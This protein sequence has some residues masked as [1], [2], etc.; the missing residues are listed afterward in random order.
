MQDEY[1]SVE[2][3]VMALLDKPDRDM[4]EIWSAFGI[5]K[6]DFQ[7]GPAWRSL[8]QCQGEQIRLRRKPM[9]PCTK[10]G[11]DLVELAQEP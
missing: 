10:Y 11:Q 4:K 8:R 3:L 5:N 1:V 6:K 9:M 7:G 2:H